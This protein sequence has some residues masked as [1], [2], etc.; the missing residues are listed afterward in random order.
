LTLEVDCRGLTCLVVNHFSY[1]NLTL[2]FTGSNLA[3]I[4]TRGKEHIFH[5]R[6]DKHHR[7]SS[8]KYGSAKIQFEATAF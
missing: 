6:A 8:L 3:G 1:N 2:S 5:L 7:L 4:D